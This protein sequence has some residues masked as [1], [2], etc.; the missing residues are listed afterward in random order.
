MMMM[1]GGHV[2]I[3]YK[4]INYVLLFYVE[5]FDSR[6]SKFITNDKMTIIHENKKTSKDRYQ[7]KQMSKCILDL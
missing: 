3:N 2:C 6:W 5:R 7:N 1:V 4:K